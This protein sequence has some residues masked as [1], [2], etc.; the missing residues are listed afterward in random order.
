MS[1]KLSTLLI[2]IV[3]LLIGLACAGTETAPDDSPT[4]LP[5]ST[6]TL[7]SDPSPT[8][9]PEASATPLPDPGPT[10]P[11]GNLDT[12][13]VARV[14][15]GDTIELTDGR[16]VRYI[17][18]NTPERGQPYYSEASEANRQLVDGRQVQLEFDQDT[19][20]Q[21]GRTLAYI[22]ADGVLVNLEIIARGYANAF[23]VPPN[24]K[25]D[26]DFR[27]AEREARDAGRG[28][29]AGSAVPLKITNLH[30]DAPGSDRDNPNGEWVEITNQGSE[31][32]N[33]AG[34]TLKDEANHIYTFGNFTVNRGAAFRLY[35]G[36]GQNTATDLYWG[37]IGESVWN[38]DSDAAFLRDKDGALVDT[39][40][41]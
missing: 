4:T 22:W 3:C 30:A 32:V 8:Q 37:Y 23:T 5:V 38:N 12:A 31:P 16:R 35:S 6:A 10:Q 14:V 29:W 9:P 36:Q 1:T 13:T 34:Y 21:Y 15:D 26:A 33:L 39:Y 24:V 11:G 25:Y 40:A 28:L 7:P 2:P 27:Q 17:G 19:F 20:D 18:V 41:Y